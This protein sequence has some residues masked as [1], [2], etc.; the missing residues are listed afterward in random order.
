MKPI[1]TRISSSFCLVIFAFSLH[2][3]ISMND[4]NLLDYKADPES[5]FDSTLTVFS[6]RG[7]WF[8]FSYPTRPEHYGGFMGPYL[9]GENN[10]TWLGSNTCQ[11]FIEDFSSKRVVDWSGFEMKSTSFRSHLIQMFE[12]VEYKIIQTLIFTS[13]RSAILYTQVQNKTE[14]PKTLKF[15]W[16]FH[17]L[18]PNLKKLPQSYGM[19]YKSNSSNER[20]MIYGLDAF[21]YINP[22]SEYPIQMQEVT[23]EPGEMEELHIG[24]TVMF[25]G[26]DFKDEEKIQK[27]WKAGFLDSLEK[28]QEGKTKISHDLQSKMDP[29]FLDSAYVRVLNKSLLTLQNNWRAAADLLTKDGIFPSYADKEYNGFW[30]WDSW[31]HAVAI[32][33]FDSVLA[34]NQIRVMYEYMDTNGFI[35]NCVFRDTNSIKNNYRNTQPPLSGWAIWEV[36]RQTR[37]QNFL[38]EMY[39][40]LLKQHQW[41]YIY[42]DHDQDGIC[43]YGSQDGSL[44]AAR[45]ESG[46]DNAVRFDQSKLLSIGDT[47]FSLDQESVDLNCYLMQEKLLLSYMA[48]SM[49]DTLN[50]KRMK[51]EAKEL[52]DK[53]QSQFYDASTGWFYD[54]K[55]DGKTFVKT[56]GCEGWS[57]LWT[58]AAS[59]EQAEKVK[60]QMMIPEQFF[61]T[62]P[63]QTLSANDPEF[64]PKDGYWRGPVWI[65]QAYFGVRGLT[66]Y[67]FEAEAKK[68]TMRLLRNANGVTEKGEPL[69][70][71]YHPQTGEGMNAKHFSWTAAHYILLLLN[72]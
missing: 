61:G 57:P 14:K 39:P 16:R 20:V 2:S 67:G 68:A 66:N 4:V 7:A 34:K 36:Y 25:G 5:Y 53:I 28:Y 40:K 27:K 12:S 3:Q 58:R 21:P 50:A 11:L 8:G 13:K 29:N 24:F 48:I 35:P 70:E 55:I 6:D 30:A 9:M 65:D 51:E 69:R 38:E 33:Y 41:W 44:E 23:I 64:K 42:R 19:L 52:M 17:P 72:K 49:K 18:M 62:V 22:R 31:K 10:G 59:T 71:T 1:L 54:T 60:E 43:E 47:L 46:M 45:W 15:K 63:F 32:S 56:M 37:D 26:D